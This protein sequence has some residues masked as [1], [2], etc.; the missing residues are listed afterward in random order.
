MEPLP[1]LSLLSTSSGPKSARPY[2]NPFVMPEGS[3]RFQYREEENQRQK[4]ELAS[5][6]RMSLVQRTDMMTPRIPPLVSKATMK[7]HEPGSTRGTVAPR[8]RE[9]KP[10]PP[11]AP[12][13][14]KNMRMTEFVAQKREIF[15]V[16]LLI[17]RKTR[18]MTRLETE[19]RAEERSLL[20]TENAL[21]EASNQ[22]K[23]ATAQAEAALTRARK[24]LEAATRNRVEL[25]RE[26]K[27]VQQSSSIMHSEISKNRDTLEAYRKY[28]EFL[29]NITP[30]GRTMEDFYKSPKLLEEEMDNL[31]KENLFLIEQYENAQTELAKGEN[32]ESEMLSETNEELKKVQ[33][34][35]ARVPKV[36]D[37]PEIPEEVDRETSAAVDKELDDINGLVKQTYLNCFHAEA[38]ISAMMMLERLESALEDMYVKMEYVNP[39]FAAEK[40]AKKDYLRA[41]QRRAQENQRREA[42]QRLKIEHALERATRPIKKRTGRPMMR[43][44]LPIKIEEQDDE[45]LRAQLREQERIETLLYGEDTD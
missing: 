25:Q 27:L 35:L 45:Q 6:H 29:V 9:V 44:M 39:A 38:N 3:D 1:P 19:M 5:I 16:Q 32:V 12:N 10:V 40:Q 7:V 34:R 28:H 2:V 11:E 23:M 42:E 18:E 43:R 37:M 24:S 21:S 31:E 15:L 4:A 22:Y 41:E 30:Q 33:E 8:T 20:E 26:Y 36:E 17:E 14:A 13:T